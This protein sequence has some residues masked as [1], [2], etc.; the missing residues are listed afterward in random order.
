MR[1]PPRLRAGDR[2]AVVAPSG[3]VD[4]HRLARGCDRLR[5]WGLEVVL[6]RHVSNRTGYLAGADT[7]RAADFTAAWADPTVAAVVCARGGYGAQRMVDLVDWPA[8]AGAPP[9]L[10]VGS[11]DITTLHSAVARFLDLGSVFGP[12]PAGLLAEP[13]ADEASLR[14]LW[15]VLFNPEA[16]MDLAPRRL[17]TV[18]GGRASGVL[19]G[20]TL[21][22]LAAEL[23][24]PA[25]PSAQGCLVFLEDVGEAPYRLDR[26]LTSLLRAGWFAGVAGIVLGTLT[27]CDDSGRPD[28]AEVVAERLGPLGVP[29][30]AGLAAGHGPRQ[31]SVPLGPV[32]DLDADAGRLRLRE[33]ALA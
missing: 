6:G 26:M 30:V 5:G 24:S 19:R 22:L 4:P 18:V 29:I 9:K 23:G 27:D 13:A 33:P 21:A 20:G 28:A 25:A 8:L 14:S 32:A 12:M 11:S 3:P 16:A 7:D 15:D 2:V 31:L 1:R 10:L 17:T